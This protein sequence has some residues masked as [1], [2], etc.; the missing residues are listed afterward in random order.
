MVFR[1]ALIFSVVCSA[2]IIS[3]VAGNG[4]SGYTGNGGSAT[5]AALGAPTGVAVDPDG[6]IY[7][8]EQLNNLLREVNSTGTLST[9]AGC[10]PATQ[11]LLSGL[12][13]GGP[14]TGAF[15]SPSDVT[16]DKA[17]NVYFSDNSHSLVRKV[18]TK[19]ILTIVAGNSTASYSGDGVAATSAALNDPVGMAVDAAGNLYI[20]D[21]LNNRIRKVSSA[22]GVISTVAGNGMYGFGGDGSAATSAML[23]HPHGVAVDSAGNL[24]ISDTLNFRVREVDTN[25]FI[26]TIAGNGMVGNTGD[27]GQATNASLTDPW[28]I[29]VDS[30]G[31]VYFADWLNNSVR[32]INTAGVISTIAGGGTGG[33]GDGGPAT[34]AT[35]FAP[36]GIAL[37]GAGNLYIADYSNNRIRKVT[38]VTSGGAGAAGTPVITLVANAE[39]ETPTIAANTWVEIKGTSLAPSGDIRTWGAADFVNGQLPTSLDGVGVKVNGQ[40][41]Y[42]YYIS[43]TQINILTPPETITGSVQVTVTMGGVAS[44]PFPV[45]SAAVSPSLFVFNGGPYV[46]AEHADYSFIG[47][48]TLYPGLTTPAKPGETISIYAN[49]FG[50]TSATV[51]PG[52]ETQSGNLPSFPVVTIGGQPSVVTFAGLVYPGEY[53]INVV[54]PGGLADGDHAVTMLYGGVQTQSGVLITTKM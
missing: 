52:A 42:V 16:T 9:F 41:A 29:Q 51:V 21:Q 54:V 27:G 37:D 23:A 35:L 34:S 32:K 2:Q 28:G 50:A 15:V 13:N 10:Y 22:T 20:A 33:L 12:G 48:T 25:G 47:P 43:P 18:D 19:G 53:L 38:G 45:Q 7:F 39:G 4:T 31:N 44:A 14:A 26:R 6:N 40:S 36:E 5:S 24:Y 11:C 17:G 46:A 8:A 3:T 49:G 1:I 30:S